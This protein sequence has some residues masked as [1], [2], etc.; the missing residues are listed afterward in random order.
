MPGCAKSWKGAGSGVRPPEEFQIVEKDRWQMMQG[1]GFPG[2]AHR[3][4]AWTGLWLG[5]FTFWRV[6]AADSVMR[7]VRKLLTDWVLPR[8]N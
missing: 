7:P 3:L 8:I 6:V 1:T 4:A 2:W 5:R